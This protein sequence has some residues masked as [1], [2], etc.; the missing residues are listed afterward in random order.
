MTYEGRVAYRGPLAF[1]GSPK[2][3]FDFTQHEAVIDEAADRPVLHPYPDTLPSG[4]TVRTYSF[5]ELLAEKTR[6][7]LERSRPRD[8]YDI[9]HL[10]EKPVRVEAGVLCLDDEGVQFGV[11]RE[12]G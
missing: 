12:E 10:I 2:I 8:L 4:T 5:H 9:V 7:L 6:A 11:S 1:P 3:R